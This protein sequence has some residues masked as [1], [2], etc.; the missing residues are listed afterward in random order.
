MSFVLYTTLK[1]IDMNNVLKF[2]YG[3]FHESSFKL[4]HVVLT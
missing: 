2:Y 3:V 1:E 4:I